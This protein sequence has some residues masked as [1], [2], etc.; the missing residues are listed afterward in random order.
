MSRND[1]LDFVIAGAQKGGT[2]QLAEHLSRVSGI[3]MRPQE[4]PAFETP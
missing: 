3:W 4:D 2:T 1:R